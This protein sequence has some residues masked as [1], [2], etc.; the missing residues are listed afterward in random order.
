MNFIERKLVFLFLFF[1]PFL[2]FI[3]TLLD[4]ES[5]CERSRSSV[6]RFCLKVTSLGSRQ[7]MKTKLTQ[8]LY[9][10]SAVYLAH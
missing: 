2:A 3:I 10:R 1:S 6:I 9:L 8:K 4:A 7:G 5:N